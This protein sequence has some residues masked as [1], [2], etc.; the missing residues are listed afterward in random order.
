MEGGFIH[1]EGQFAPGPVSL[2]APR[3][4]LGAWAFASCCFWTSLNV[5][6]PHFHDTVLVRGRASL[7]SHTERLGTQTAVPNATCVSASVLPTVWKCGFVMSE[8]D[9]QPF[10][11]NYPGRKKEKIYFPVYQ[12]IEGGSDLYLMK[13]SF[14]RLFPHSL[15]RE[16]H[17]AFQA[18]V[19]EL[20]CDETV[21]GTPGLGDE[22]NF[23]VWGQ[24]MEGGQKAKTPGTG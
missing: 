19:L 24:N 10:L 12:E 22:E 11:D 20:V 8:L 7:R 13:I 4:P 18:C 1:S 23:K 21:A 16:E 6:A 9:L 3:L 14:Q 17:G 5:F 2:R 15:P